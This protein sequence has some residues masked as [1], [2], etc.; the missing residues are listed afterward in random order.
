M[1]IAKFST[2]KEKV[3]IDRTVDSV[4]IDLDFTQLYDCFLILAMGVKSTTA[5]QV[6]FYLLRV[7][8]RDN[9]VV[10]N[11]RAVAGFN[12][13]RTRTGQKPLSEQAFYRAVKALVTYGVMVKL[14]PSRGMYFMNPFAMWK[15]KKEARIAYLRE[16]AGPG[17]S[18]SINPMNLLLNDADHQYT[19]ETMVEDLTSEEVD[20]YLNEQTGEVNTNS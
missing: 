14:P 18:I 17:Q 12:E 3:E 16:D 5:F 6:M 7:M 13:Q 19:A 10:V 4:E 20:S 11:N 8:G 2:R 1:K 15:G 9:N